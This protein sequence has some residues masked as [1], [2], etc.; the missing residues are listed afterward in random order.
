VPGTGQNMANYQQFKEYVPH[1]VNLF[2]YIQMAIIVNIKN[3][4]EQTI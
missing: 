1:F 2:F 3:T 4:S